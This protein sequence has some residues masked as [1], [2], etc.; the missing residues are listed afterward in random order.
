MKER[1]KESERERERERERESWLPKRKGVFLNNI[2][3]VYDVSG[4]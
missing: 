2:C 4:K 1:L 3:K